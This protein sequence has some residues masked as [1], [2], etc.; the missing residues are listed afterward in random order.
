M[1]SIIVGIIVIVL[2]IV[3]TVLIAT[4]SKR[5]KRIIIQN[6]INSLKK[7]NIS[8]NDYEFFND[9]IIGIDYD[10]KALVILKQEELKNEPEFIDLKN[11]IVCKHNIPNDRTNIK[12]NL[13]LILNT[14]DTSSFLK[15]EIYNASFAMSPKKEIE[16]IEKWVEKINSCIN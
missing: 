7:R 11:I 3:G 15:Y 10:S 4:N 12:D 9:I 8:L 1:N 5:K 6:L 16:F 2:I 14:K 13:Y